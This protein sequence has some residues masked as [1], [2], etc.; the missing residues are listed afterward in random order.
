MNYGYKL[1]YYKNSY[2]KVRLLFVMSFPKQVDI[3]FIG[4]KGVGKTSLLNRLCDPHEHVIS[5]VKVQKVEP[6][7]ARTLF[8]SSKD[9][10]SCSICDEVLTVDTIN[11]TMCG[12]YYCG[13]CGVKVERCAVCGHT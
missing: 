6:F 11:I 7:L 1:I 13:A 2:N 9:D 5:R 4:D 3:L 10:L 12:H 8:A